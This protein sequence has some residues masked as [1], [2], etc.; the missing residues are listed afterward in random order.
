MGFE[1][2]RKKNIIDNTIKYGKLLSVFPIYSF[3]LLYPNKDNK[4]KWTKLI[5]TLVKKKVQKS[6]T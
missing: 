3:F 4:T 5:G 6:R 2:K 1:M